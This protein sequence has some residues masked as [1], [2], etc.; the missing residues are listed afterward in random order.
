[1]QLGEQIRKSKEEAK[2]ELETK[3]DQQAREYSMHLLGTD[4]KHQDQLD[5][6]DE[7]WRKYFDQERLALLQRYQEKL[8]QELAAQEDII[9]Q[10]CVKVWVPSSSPHLLI[11]S[12][13]K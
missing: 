11:A 2:L 5:T 9:N 6:Q 8:D 10:R 12:R 1:M 13:S 7:D 3:L 4:V